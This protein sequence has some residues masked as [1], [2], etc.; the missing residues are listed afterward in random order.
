MQPGRFGV[1]GM[2]AFEQCSF[3][4]IHTGRD[5]G[6]LPE[7]GASLPQGGDGRILFQPK[8]QLQTV[9][10]HPGRGRFEI[11]LSTAVA[12]ITPLQTKA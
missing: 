2:R 8:H 12:T 1:A 10:E 6:T 7:D 3:S 9:R 11:Q 4:S 5:A